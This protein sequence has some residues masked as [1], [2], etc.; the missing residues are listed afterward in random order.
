MRINRRDFARGLSAASLLGAA[1]T[2]LGCGDTPLGDQTRTF[3]HARSPVAVPIDGRDGSSLKDRISLNVYSFNIAL[4]SYIQ[5]RDPARNYQL[6][7]I[8]LIQFCQMNGIAAIDPTGYYWWN[9]TTQ[10]GYPLVPVKA[11]ID[12]FRDEARKS[13]IAISG[14]GIQNNFA[15]PHAAQRESDLAQVRAWCEVAAELGAPVLRVFAGPVPPG[16]AWD[17]VAKWMAD[18]LFRCAEY[19]KAVGVKIGVQ[20]HG[21]MLKTA[22]QTIEILRMVDSEWFGAIND[23]GYFLTPNP[24]D[25]IARLLPYTITFQVKESVR[26]V[27]NYQAAWTSLLQLVGIIERSGYPGWLPVETLATV[28]P[29]DPYDPRTAVPAFVGALREAIDAVHK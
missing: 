19:G 23:T 7:L 27:K 13:G 15:S 20:N 14:T 18:C 22:E 4:N 28:D 10:R 1:A 21:D 11:D 16:Y 24:Y 6:P 26:A 29:E 12:A 8:D 9:P 2:K 25:D 17:E 5:G 3:A